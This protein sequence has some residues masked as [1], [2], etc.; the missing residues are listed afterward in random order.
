MA[1]KAQLEQQLKDMQSKLEQGDLKAQRITHDM[2]L[3]S[4]IKTLIASASNALVQGSL[5]VENT[6][7]A[8]NRVTGLVHNEIDVIEKAQDIRLTEKRH[9]L[10]ALIN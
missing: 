2:S 5:T 1:T 4:M 9:E 7:A 10:Q 8:T 6:A 3:W